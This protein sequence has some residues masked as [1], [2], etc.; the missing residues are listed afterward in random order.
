[1]YVHDVFAIKFS[2]F[3]CNDTVSY[4]DTTLI[5]HLINRYATSDFYQHGMH[6]TTFD[7]PIVTSLTRRSPTLYFLV[8]S[9]HACYDRAKKYLKFQ[10]IQAGFDLDLD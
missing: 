9:F 1:M 7:T 6:D 4:Y 5:S 3:T 8:S 2:S 10:S